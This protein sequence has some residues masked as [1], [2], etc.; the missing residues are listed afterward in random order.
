MT[1]TVVITG[2]SAGIARAAARLYGQRQANVALI[3]RGQ[4]GLEAAAE[5]VRER[6]GVPLIIQADVADAGQVDAAAQQAEDELGPIDVWINVAFT[7]VFAP[8]S[9][10]S[11][12]E[13]K[14]SPRCPTW[15]TSTGRWPRS[16]T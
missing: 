2:A 16:G 14:R 15:G 1:Q 3:A 13:F 11:A 10:I 8:F 12:A 6:G 4:A 7:S 9:E 5:D